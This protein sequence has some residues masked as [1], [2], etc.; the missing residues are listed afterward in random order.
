MFESLFL[1]PRHDMHLA[2]TSSYDIPMVITSVLIAIFASFCAFEM[3]ERLARCTQRGFWLPVGAVILGSGVWAMHFIGM[4]AFRL[5][6]EMTYEPWISAFSV[7]PAIFAAAVALDT[8][9]G[10]KISARK[11]AFGGIVMALGIGLMHF[12]GMAS[13]RLDGILRYDP[14]M[15][16]VS[17]LA[18]SALAVTAL[19]IKSFLDRLPTI[20][21]PFVS[22]LISGIVLG[23][24]I[25][26]M[27]YIAMEAAYFIHQHPGG[28]D[29]VVVASS[30]TV[31]AIAVA[32]VAIVLIFSGLLF[33][34]LGTKITNARSRIEAILNTT[35]H[36]FVMMNADN[37]ILECNHAMSML[38]GIEQAALAGQSYADLIASDNYRE[39]IGNYQVE[40]DIRRADGSLLPCLING[41]VVTDDRGD[42]LYCFA[43]LNDIT[44]RKRYETKIREN[45]QRLLDILN[46]SPIAVRIAVKQGREV[47]FYNQRYTELIK[48]VHALGEDPKKYYVSAEDYE[49]VVAE[50]ERGNVIHNL[51]IELRIPDGSRVWA[52]ASYMPIQYQGENAVLGWF[53]DITDRIEAQKALARQLELQRQA[54]ETLRITNEEQ[55]A[56]LDSATSG[57]VLTKDRII[58]R[59]N[60]KLEEIF[61]YA[62]G[63]LVGQ[64]T[65]F[66][67]PDEAAY[68]LGANMYKDIEQGEFH[69]REQQLIRKD[70][71]LFWARISAQALDSK[72]PAL[73]VVAIIDDITVEHEAAEAILKAKQIAEDATRMKS[74]FLSNM[75]HEIRTPMNAIIGLSHL[76]MKTGMTSKQR[77]YVKKIQASS[78]HLLG[79]INDILD[80]SKI[81]AGKLT[82]E[83]IDFE[84]EHVL[85]NITG[86]IHDKAAEKGLEL[87][88]DVAPQVPNMLVGDPLRLG[89]VLINFGTNAVKFTES[90]EIDVVVRKLEETEHEVVLKLSVKDTGIGLSKEQIGKLFHSFQQADS[91]TT[92]KYGGTGLGL[93]ISKSLAEM[94]G[95]TIGVD[96]EL[97]KGSEFWFTVR[98]GK[99]KQHR[100]LLLPHPDLRGKRVLVVDDNENARTVLMDLLGSMSFIVDQAAS[101]S[102]AIGAVQHAAI[103]NRAYDAIFIDWQMPNMDGIEVVRIIRGMSLTPQPKLLLVT[104]YAREEVLHGAMQA[105][106]DEIL[107]KPVNASTLF[108]S[109]VRTFEAETKLSETVNNALNTGTAHDFA[110][111]IGARIL[112]VEDNEMNQQIAQELLEDA[113]FW[114]DV[115]VHGQDA[116]EKVRQKHYD[117]VLMDMQMPVMD[118]VTATMEIRKLPGFAD[119]PIVAMTANAMQQDR[120]RCLS[121]GMNDHIAKPIEPEDLLVAL[122][123]WIKPHQAD[124]QFQ[125]NNIS[126]VDMNIAIPEGIE[127]LDTELGLRRMQGKLGLYV[128]MLNKFVISQ[129]SVAAQIQD[130]LEANDYGTAERLAHTLKSLAGNIGAVSLQAQAERLETILHANPADEQ[131]AAILAETTKQLA[132]L[133]DALWNRLAPSADVVVPTQE[134]DAAKLEQVIVHFAQ[135]LADDDAESNDCFSAH[136]GLLHAAFPA[137]FKRLQQAMRNYD[138]EDALNILKEASAQRQITWQRDKT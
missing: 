19:L 109:V 62:S 102:I 27:H 137:Q 117:I 38:A 66:W 40:A 123:K 122:R 54:E 55:R 127:G 79:I 82:M 49:K 75:S 93:A 65:R 18:A 130:A 60:H 83:R 23:G 24:A 69:R 72:N 39:M 136:T 5:N 134:I 12:S 132:E 110:D 78:Q 33:T 91:S 31:L 92:R 46:V 106:I 48:N 57:I 7:V 17:L 59:G 81:E 13:I 51:Q 4:L 105:G 101:G 126:T 41:N 28:N 135:L 129:E 3:V 1:N 63:E 26:S 96:S 121:A 6:C 53:Y 2:Y 95:G 108:D 47:V 29:N 128:S 15:F 90:G 77:D 16:V 88:I 131:L 70:G 99:S 125:P 9:A 34:F 64:P 80:F 61:G 22:S 36:G 120:E 103:N 68:E 10:E 104:A 118:G 35:S 43:L 11:L 85:D 42:F 111:I 116:L 138:F 124:A 14:V 58:L 30:P 133:V 114:V 98:L 73:G 32:A 71:S 119:L 74:D 8:I 25:S 37:T 113:G 20:T 67:Y 76:V 100:R 89:Q 44:E 94:M 21:L 50:L 115:A 45:E 87:I 112:L 86:L 84:L 107:I 56:I 97:G 52:L